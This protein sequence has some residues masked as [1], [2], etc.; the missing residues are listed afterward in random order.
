[1]KILLLGGTTE[2]RE[3][4]ASG[5]PL[6]YSVA[7]EYGAELAGRPGAFASIAEIRVGRMDAKNMELF[8]MENEIAGVIDATHPH[9]AEVSENARRACERTFAPYVRVVREFAQIDLTGVTVIGSCGEAAKLLN[10]PARLEMK[11][12]LA[13]G[14]KEL[15]CFTGVDDYRKRLFVRVLPVAEVIRSCEKMGFDAGQLIAMQGPFSKAM[16]EATLEM[17]GA[18]VLVTKDSGAAGGLGEK[19]GAARERGVEVLLIRRPEETGMTVTEAVEWGRRL[20]RDAG[21]TAGASSKGVPPRGVSPRGVPLF[22][23]FVSIADRNV[24]VVGGGS[25][26]LRRVRTLLTCGARVTV[27]S[28]EFHKDFGALSQAY[29]ENLRLIESRCK[30]QDFDGDGVLGISMIVLATDDRKLNGGIGERARKAGIPVSVADA[31]EECTFFFPSLVTEGEIVAAVSAGGRPSLNR[32]LAH[33]LRG[34]WRSWVEEAERG[35]P[36]DS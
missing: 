28:P 33:R 11:A 5:L 29:K 27:V 17:T 26:A 15:A 36:E 32:R 31:S 6:V 23:F 2:G 14:S 16:N 30:I 10:E 34:V 3:I 24:L 9:A 7:T 18:R 1:M 35:G 20:L 21:G 19:L 8:I 22:P 25:V 4:L 12:L 13:V